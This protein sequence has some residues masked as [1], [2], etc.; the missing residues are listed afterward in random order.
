MEIRHFNIS[1]T[2]AEYGRERQTV[3]PADLTAYLLDPMP[4]APERLRPSV[5][6]CPGGG[7]EFVSLREDQPVAMEFLSAGCQVFVL[8]YHV[9]PEVFPLALME[10]AR[11]I[12]LVRDH[13]Q[14]WN[15]DSSQIMV[16]GF[17]A[18]GHLAACLGM[19]WNRSFL[20]EPLGCRSEYLRPDGMILCYPVITS[21]E[22]GH[23]PS[24]EHL[25]GKKGAEDPAMRNLVS[26]ELQAGPH[27]PRTFLWHTWTDQSVPVENSLLLAQALR[28]AGVSLEMHIYPEGRHGLALATGEVSDA[29]GDC[30]IP[31]CQGWISLVKE[32]MEIM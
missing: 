9:D 27:V 11:S 12:A 23:L 15:I 18:G 5:I 1:V 13:A 16:C 6:I 22:Y 28:K 21:G 3:K 8:H 19:M 20:Y 25:L 2:P 29:S 7:Y 4:Q 10:L 32:W 17:S 26:L 31:H 24:F 30:F 14:E